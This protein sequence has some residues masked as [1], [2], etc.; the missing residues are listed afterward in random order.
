[1]RK[2]VRISVT[3]LSAV[4]MGTGV[5]QVGART[6]KVTTTQATTLA[7]ARAEAKS[8]GQRTSAGATAMSMSN[9]ASVPTVL[10]G[11]TNLATNVGGSWNNYA[12]TIPNPPSCPNGAANTTSCPNGS[13]G[14][15][16]AVHAVQLYD[17]K[18]LIMAGS[19][20]QWQNLQ[21]GAF[22]SWV[23]DPTVADQTRAWK[24]VP[25][26][27]DMFCAGH[28]QLSDGNILITGGTRA[29]PQFD[30]TGNLVHDWDGSKQTYIFDVASETYLQTGSMA[31]A[32]WYP[33]V[34]SV[35][36][37]KILVTGGL[38]DAARPLGVVTHNTDT[39]ELY[40]PATGRWTALPTM[41]FSLSDPPA[42]VGAGTTNSTRTF[43]FYPGMT[44][45]KGGNLFYSGESNGNNGVT[46]GI[47]NWKTGAWTP[48]KPLP[49]NYQRTAG[50][51]VLLPPAQNQRVM[52]MGGGDYLAPTTN[53]TEII[54]L[55]NQ[56]GNL[57]WT[58][59]PAMSAAKMYVGAV[60]LPDYN[61]FETNGAAQLRQTGVHTAEE[62]NPVT[63]TFT[64][65]NSPVEDR[66]YHSNAFLEPNG[67]VA[68]MGSQPLDGSFNM[69]IAIYSPP[70][71]FKGARP[72]VAGLTNRFTYTATP[73]GRY[74][75][76]LA[77]GTTLK[78]ASLIRPSA[79]THSTDPDQRLIQLLITHNADG[80]YS[81]T[82]PTDDTVAPEGQYMLFVT[83]SRGVPSVAKWVSI[84]VPK[85]T[86]TPPPP[87]PGPMLTLTV[88]S[89]SGWVAHLTATSS[90][91]TANQDVT[92]QVLSG[93]T[94]TYATNS[95][96]DATGRTSFV[97]GGGTTMQLRAMIPATGVTSNQVSVTYGP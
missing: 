44:L 49:F 68:I 11:P 51:T 79:T 48:T 16:G 28:E 85:A 53:D 84:G 43:P 19:G 64:V 96:T 67:Q 5:A 39:N 73:Q 46:P 80:T 81:F 23:W 93:T 30:S 74:T 75:I 82:P 42:K 52:I 2:I 86:G 58:K 57:T 69:H 36:G 25:T 7:Q 50:A 35:G 10:Q 78:Y 76:R 62:Y 77:S 20:N 83:D 9:M 26:P 37:G 54:N 66:L 89:M 33:T 18:V 17:G 91:A 59:G 31:N 24:F 13:N 8:E 60:I 22:T 29:Y 21:T 1:M 90:V 65:M 87:P 3:T 27:Y 32:R 88:D 56:T 95:L 45:L 40:D 55:S 94:W 71:L 92:L 34:V 97:W 14:P 41:D 70:Y 15:S 6:P 38:D 12:F 47:W 63:N 61:V 72:V 4:L